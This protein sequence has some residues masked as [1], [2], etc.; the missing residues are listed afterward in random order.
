MTVAMARP[1]PGLMGERAV[2]VRLFALALLAS[3]GCRSILGIEEASS[4]DAGPGVPTVAFEATQSGADE[5]SGTVMI[6]V[7]LS[8]PADAMVSVEYTLLS[9]GSATPNVDFTFTG[10]TLVFAPGDDRREVAV[11]INDDTNDTESVETFD[12]TLS[13]VEGA[14]IDETRAIHSVQIADHILPRVTVG[15]GN[16]MS[17]EST[18]S[19]LIVKLDR[20]S[21]GQSTVVIGVVGG[22]PFPATAADI[23]LTD[24]TQV[25]ISDGAQMMMVP[26]GEK[27]D[28]LDEEDTETVTLSLRTPSANLVLGT[29]KSLTH[30]VL[31]N[32]PP[33]AVSF[34][35]ATATVDEDAP[36]GIVVDVRLNAAS[37]RTISVPFTVGGGTATA[38]V[39]YLQLDPSPLVF[40]PGQTQ[41]SISIDVPD[42][43]PQNENNETVLVTLGSPTNAT[44]GTTTT[45]TL[46]IVE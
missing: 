38:G 35:T 34:M 1:Y 21:E 4:H 32:D 2:N 45:F 18:A 46:T 22:N 13:A 39:D 14:T 27:N 6:P 7:V 15:P 43:A 24:G 9:G 36:G 25:V 29:P 42:S 26:I 40:Q 8:R 17:N 10:G 44:L 31:D 3:A 28:T 37:A 33:P 16:T 11:T 23:T 19:F 30:S 5:K 41:R 12:I 20:P